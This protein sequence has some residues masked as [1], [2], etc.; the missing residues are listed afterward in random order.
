MRSIVV[1]SLYISSLEALLFPKPS[2]HATTTSLYETVAK[3]K[4][5]AG[6]GGGMSKDIGIPCQDE[7]ALPS[8]P[9]LPETI[10]PGV[11]SGQAQLD[12]LKHAKENGR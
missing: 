3:T 7:C 5:V 4:A 9:N 8:Y 1:L 11:L 10:H 6:V 2:F 12:L